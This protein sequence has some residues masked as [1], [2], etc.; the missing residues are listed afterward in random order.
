MSNSSPS[1]FN[2]LSMAKMTPFHANLR[3]K[4]GFTEILV[5]AWGGGSDYTNNHT[6]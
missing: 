4:C 2:L 1:V 6:E 5:N 3:C